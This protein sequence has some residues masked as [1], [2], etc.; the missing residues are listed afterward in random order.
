MPQLIVE[1]GSD[2]NSVEIGAGEKLVVGRDPKAALRLN[3]HASSRRHFLILERDGQYYLKD[4]GSQ[5]GTQVN[6][7][8][9]EKARLAFGDT[10]QVGG[11]VMRLV[12]NGAAAA[13]KEPG[14]AAGEGEDA[15]SERDSG[16]NGRAGRGKDTGSRGGLVGRELCGYRFEKRLGRGSMGTVYVA[17]QL[18]LERTV[19]LKVLS[20]E[21]LKKPSFIDM[22]RS[23]ARA[24]G[25]LNHPNI[26][27]V[28][29]VLEYKG[30]HFYSMEFA[31]NGSVQDLIE[32]G[33]YLPLP[34][35]LG[36]LIDA[37]HA[38]V[39][40][41]K[42]QLVHRDIKPDNLFLNVDGTAKIGDLGLAHSTAEGGE[43]LA[44][45]FGT[46]HFI[47]PEQA[48]GR[49]IDHRADIYALGATFYR[50]ITGQTPYRGRDVKEILRRHVKEQPP[51]AAERPSELPEETPFPAVPASVA[52][53]IYKMMAK[54]PEE[55]YV[56]AGEIIPELEQTRREIEMNERRSARAAGGGLAPARRGR[57][58]VASSS[59]RPHHAEQGEPSPEDEAANRK[60]VTKMLAVGIGAFVLL[61]GLSVMAG[62]MLGGG[63]TDEEGAETPEEPSTEEEQEPGGQVVIL[64]DEEPEPEETP[65]REETNEA[66]ERQELT[67]AQ[68]RQERARLYQVIRD[69]VR[70]IL[71]EHDFTRRAPAEF[72]VVEAVRGELRELAEFYGR[73]EVFSSTG[74][75]SRPEVERN[76]ARHIYDEFNE[77]YEE[78]RPLAQTH[79]QAFAEL[80]EEVAEA[81]ADSRYGEAIEAYEAYARRYWYDHRPP[82]AR[83]LRGTSEVIGRLHDFVEEYAPSEVR[84]VGFPA[85]I[86]IMR[87]PDGHVWQVREKVRNTFLEKMRE[88]DEALRQDSQIDDFDERRARLMPLEA[89]FLEVY[90]EWRLDNSE[91]VVTAD[92][93]DLYIN[94]EAA[95]R[96]NR[97]RRQISAINEAELQ[98][99]QGAF[100]AIR[101]GI[102][103]GFERAQQ[104]MWKLDFERALAPFEALRASEAFRELER[105]DVEAFVMLRDIIRTKEAQLRRAESGFHA[106]VAGLDDALPLS[107]A[108]P[109]DLQHDDDVHGGIARIT[110]TGATPEAL[111]LRG[112]DEPQERPWSVLIEVRAGDEDEDERTEVN[113]EQFY[114]LLERAINLEETD[115]PEVLLGV[116]ALL[117]E[118]GDAHRLVATESG[119]AGLMERAL[120]DAYGKVHDEAREYMA[121]ALILRVYELFEQ[122]DGRTAQALL[123]QFND[124]YTD[125]DAYEYMTSERAERILRGERTLEGGEEDFIDEPDVGPGPDPSGRHSDETY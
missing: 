79:E 21:L 31:E 39:Y 15:A 19:A 46:P 68:I 61:V 115:D 122:G 96:I 35:A 124:E 69:E 4:L 103:E 93:G 63:G 97:L 64:D 118:L 100:V 109:Q 22:F 105:D 112:Y 108:R 74:R 84:L 111:T 50:I 71:E 34:Q 106:I 101:D 12:E 75:S 36:I 5:N 72:E 57:G 87:R 45:V 43:Q 27:Q 77:V 6:G 14:D 94:T 70:E 62:I 2:R 107:M 33:R 104:A 113:L 92:G 81:L 29:D 59:Y 125:T 83:L 123:G 48:L 18:S 40:A 66:E 86:E 51:Y 54:N 28:Y 60:K 37:C 119:R 44:G 7:T 49:A 95:E 55:R 42:K 56:S 24:A 80:E 41:E 26:I 23:E 17:T 120:E 88:M 85:A 117:L 10:I 91:F 8:V 3:D 65:E 53:I 9:V 110:I 25:K 98:Q 13:G 116:S 30:L 58:A 78:L 82:Q 114:D 90:E 1:S 76:P 121:W 73:K 99:L 89:F 16:A 102:R 38:L 11:T 47:A 52:D 67:P 32:D 20:P